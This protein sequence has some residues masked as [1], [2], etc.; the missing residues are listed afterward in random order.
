MKSKIKF[1]QSPVCL[2][3]EDFLPKETNKAILEEAISLKDMFKAATIGQGKTD[4][5]YRDNLV[6]Y[7]DGIFKSKREFSVLL[8][9]FKEKFADIGFREILASSPSP[10][11]DFWYTNFHETQVSRYGNSRGQ[12]YK[13]HIDNMGSKKRHITMVYYFFKEPK[14]FS[15]GEIFLSAS[16]QS[17]GEIVD[18]SHKEIKIIP[19]NNMCIVFSSYTPHRVLET[20]SPEK[21]EDGRFSANVWIGFA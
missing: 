12:H 10:I 2:I 11:R 13:Y 8:K 5:E 20:K 17:R 21:F 7:Y 14:K 16:P 1:I 9:A 18:K 3:F 6:L 4:L 15:G 19:K